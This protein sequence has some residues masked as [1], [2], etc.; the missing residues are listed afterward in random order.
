MNPIAQ[1]LFNYLRDVL[2]NPGEAVLD[3]EKLP[4][5]FQ[6]FGSGLVYVVECIMET[7]EVAEA[8]SK[9]DFDQK[10]PSR[11][12]EFAAPLKSLHASLMHLTWQAQ[13]I[14]QGDYN[15]RV[16]FMG[17]F[18]VAFNT[19][20][21]QLA[22]R[23]QKLEEKIIK[24][25]DKTIALERS[26]SLVN[27]LMRHI[28]QQIIVVDIN[29]KE[30][31]IMNDVAICEMEN[32]AEYFEE[33]MR[34]ILQDGLTYKDGRNN[35]ITLV[36][37]EGG[38]ERHFRIETHLIEW[39]NLEAKV[40]TVSDITIAKHKIEL[41]ESRAYRDQLTKSYNRTFGMMTLDK[42]LD[43]DRKFALI[44]ADLDNLKY[45][46]DEFGHSEGDVYISTAARYL[47]SFSPD[48]V[49]CRV[50]GDEFMLLVPNIS[51]EKVHEKMNALAHK[52]SIDDYLE[53]K[54]YSYSISF[55]VVV[56]EGTNSLSASDIL[57]IA[58]ERM[59]ENKRMRKKSRQMI[60]DGA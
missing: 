38:L 7:K 3:V 60:K 20:V 25:Q 30:I 46:N 15:Q 22:E 24:L 57:G 52:F 13:Q 19:M 33:L 1:N 29:T 8:F 54:K 23:Q 55:G 37:R 10:L 32:D 44:F 49:A 18:S 56:V 12:N 48:A 21:E 41:L 59:Y 14:A 45:I 17:E 28:S 43:E 26:N 53:D 11:N 34:I 4:E 58:D 5:E 6:E 27:S 9:G 2:Y 51:W 35:E 36:N 16:A 42:W 31:L 39:N 50:G 47:K 40:F